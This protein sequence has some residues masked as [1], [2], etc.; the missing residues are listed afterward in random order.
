MHVAVMIRL[1]KLTHSFAKVDLL[2]P[3]RAL[4]VGGLLGEMGALRIHIAI[5]DIRVLLVVAVESL[6][7]FKPTSLP[8][9]FIEFRPF[10]FLITIRGHCDCSEICRLIRMEE[11][12]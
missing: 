10:A 4:T 8:A 3:L 9:G 7:S 12:S 11:Q 2:A 1:V 6:Y 5:A